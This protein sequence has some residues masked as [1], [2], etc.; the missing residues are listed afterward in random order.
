MPMGRL[1]YIPKLKIGDN[2]YNTLVG[3]WSQNNIAATEPDYPQVTP[4]NPYF[5]P[6]SRPRFADFPNAI[7]NITLLP[8]ACGEKNSVTSSSKNVSPEAPSR[9]A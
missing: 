5:Y 1:G 2:G 4:N 7:R 3:S 8:A 9:W 6:F